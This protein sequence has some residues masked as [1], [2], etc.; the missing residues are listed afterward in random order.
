MKNHPP[1][2]RPLRRRTR[3]EHGAAAVEFALVSSLLFMLLFGV[4]Q[5][6]LYFN[7]SLNVR[8]GVRDS[9][10]Q[11][12]VENFPTCSGASSNS[13]KLVCG[14]KAQ[15]GAVTGTAY[16]KVSVPSSGWAKGQPLTVCAMVRSEGAIGLVPMPN[17]GWISSKT[18]M[19]I[20]QEKLKATWTNAADTL[21]SGQSWS[22]C[23]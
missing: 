17:S 5:Y 23:P 2:R 9:A 15:I 16:V 11:G 3:T 13:A 18:Q 19:F 1:L 10:R 12:A 22:W 14:T 21:P 4:I 6:G 8:Q 20:E 7:D